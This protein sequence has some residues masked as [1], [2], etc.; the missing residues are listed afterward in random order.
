[1]GVNYI[2]NR[3]FGTVQDEKFMGA[4]W[5]RIMLSKKKT[6]KKTRRVHEMKG[7]NEPYNKGVK[8]NLFS[9]LKFFM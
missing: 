6:F 9:F 5:S 7:G 3:G 1:M 4:D 2:L 8:G